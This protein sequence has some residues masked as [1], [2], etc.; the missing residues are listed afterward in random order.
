MNLWLKL[1]NRTAAKN[2]GKQ[3]NSTNCTMQLNGYTYVYI[4]KA[5]ISKRKCAHNLCFIYN[6][7]AVH[8]QIYWKHIRCNN[9]L[10]QTVHK[11]SIAV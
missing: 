3:Q 6:I 7:I 9:N 10:T 1:Q 8:I 4:F 5:A 11:L 2:T